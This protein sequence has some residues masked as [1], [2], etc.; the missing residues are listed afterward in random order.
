M[1]ISKTVLEK[2]I[3]RLRSLAYCDQ[4]TNC[5][6]RNWLEENREKLNFSKKFIAIVDI[7]NLKDI[8]DTEGH[9][10]GDKFICQIADKLKTFGDVVRLGGDEFLVIMDNRDELEKHSHEGFIYACG[11][12]QI[13]GSFSD[14]MEIADRKMYDH[15]KNTK[16]IERNSGKQKRTS[17]YFL[18]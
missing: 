5:Y 1:G 6:N 10:K 18:K 4:L 9:M 17:K 15:K 12:E 11:I 13:N 14:A 16:M 2:E 3:A 8:N 7:N